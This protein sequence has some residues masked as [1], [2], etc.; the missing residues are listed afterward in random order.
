MISIQSM[1]GKGF[2][3][4]KMKWPKFCDKY[5]RKKVDDGILY[6]LNKDETQGKLPITIDIDL[7][8][9]E[10]MK[11]DDLLV[12][13]VELANVVIRDLPKPVEVTIAAR[14]PYDKKG[15]FHAG[16]HLWIDH[17]LNLQDHKNLR[18]Q[19]LKT[20]WQDFFGTVNDNE[21]ILDIGVFN[22]TIKGLLII[23]QGKWRGNKKNAGG[24]RIV[25]Q[26]KTD[27]HLS[28][29]IGIQDPQA[30]Q[31]EQLVKLY[32]WLSEPLKITAPKIKKVK[33][34]EVEKFNLDEYL[35]VQSDSPNQF[36]YCRIC[37]YFAYL[38]L[39][40]DLTEQKCNAV[41]KP[42][43]LRET[44]KFIRK[45][46]QPFVRQKGIKDMLDRAGYVY[47]PSKIWPKKNWCH[48]DFRQFVGKL[49]DPD[50]IKDFLTAIVIS[51]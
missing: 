7:D 28:S 23:G 47:D 51:A 8:F 36:I 29:N 34:T 21:S 33:N 11:T 37:A 14:E 40:P 30:D 46:D 44:S 1:K 48:G 43:K 32:K 50:E 17:K 31:Y 9:E 6:S 38:G 26:Q 3:A 5:L 19:L 18:T 41:W 45:T 16:F 12:K 49:V 42:K 13:Y 35:K 22:R 20:D 2:A 15:K 39:D 4:K 25:F 10:K 24:Q 27:T